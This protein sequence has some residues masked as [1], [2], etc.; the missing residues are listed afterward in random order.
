MKNE[1]MQTKE[2]REDMWES[3]KG[4]MGRDKCCNYNV[5][6]RTTKRTMFH[7]HTHAFTDRGNLLT[8]VLS[9]QV[10]QIC[11][12]EDIYTYISVSYTHL[13]LPTTTRV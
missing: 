4:V 10:I 5:K 9:S 1:A 11:K 13:T 6:I 3:L 8:E 7:R 2:N 12:S